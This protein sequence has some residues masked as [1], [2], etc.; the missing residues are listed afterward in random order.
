MLSYIYYVSVFY[1]ISLSQA[2]VLKD[3]LWELKGKQNPHPKDRRR[4]E[5]PP[6]ARVLPMGQSVVI[7]LMTFPSKLT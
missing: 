7:S 3:S 2:S 5:E 1:A 6:G 4:V